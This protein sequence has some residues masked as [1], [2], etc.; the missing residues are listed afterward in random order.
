MGSK[1]IL[2]GNFDSLVEQRSKAVKIFLSSTF[3]G[4]FFFVNK[5][6]LKLFQ[7]THTERDYLIKNI[8]PKLREYCQKTHGLDF[9]VYDMRWGIS[10][11]ITTSHMTTTVCLN[12]IKNCQNSSVGPNFI[13]IKK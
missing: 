11:E 1:D 8:Y 9:Q 3:S 13:V 5:I 2:R 4:N 7:D 12:E 6:N 10:N